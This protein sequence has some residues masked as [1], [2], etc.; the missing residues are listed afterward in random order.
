MIIRRGPLPAA[1]LFAELSSVRCSRGCV[2]AALFAV[3][4]VVCLPLAIV[5][6]KKKR[7]KKKKEKRKKKRKHKVKG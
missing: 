4:W 3:S 5:K 1:V 2:S 6:K 7:K